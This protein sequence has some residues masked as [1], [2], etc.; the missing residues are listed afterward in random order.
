[1]EFENKEDLR[2][3]EN[4]K[5]ILNSKIMTREKIGENYRDLQELYDDYFLN[6]TFFSVSLYQ[7]EEYFIFEEIEKQK[8]NTFS[9]KALNEVYAF[10]KELLKYLKKEDKYRDIYLLYCY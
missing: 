2:Q 6:D 10:E 9:I 8:K 1:M 4:A 5:K 7:F 3:F